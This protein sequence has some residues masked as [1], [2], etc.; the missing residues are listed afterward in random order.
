MIKLEYLDV[1]KIE[2]YGRNARMH[3]P[4]QIAQLVNS[5]TE[6][7][8]TNPVL[9]DG[10][11]VLIAGHGRL[12][13]A[14][15]IGM[16]QVPAIR[17][18]NLTENQIKAL[19][20][21]DNQLALNATWDIDLLTAELAELNDESFDLDLLGFDDDFISGLLD[22]D[23]DGLDDGFGS[24][25]GEAGDEEE[26]ADVPVVIGPYKLN[27]PRRQWDKWESKLRAEVGFDKTDIEKAIMK[28]LAIKEG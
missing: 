28:R 20:I 23:P 16:K 22:E 4:E 14:T 10:N 3:S 8:F 9:V 2:T 11:N 24:G 12:T 1:S 5:I 17:L 15:E 6:F 27:V 13:A 7:G 25:E 26:A 18:D 21:A 19:R